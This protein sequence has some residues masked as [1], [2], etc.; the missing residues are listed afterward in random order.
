MA[1]KIV[2]FILLLG[3]LYWAYQTG[4]LDSLSSGNLP[5]IGKE[6]KLRSARKGAGIPIA[7]DKQ[8]IA[9][10]ID[11]HLGSES[12]KLVGG[13]QLAGLY[14]NGELVKLP[15]DTKARVAERSTVKVQSML[16]QI[17][18]VRILSGNNKGAVGW[19]ERENV[20]DTPLHEL[21]QSV[22]SG[23]GS[24]RRRHNVGGALVPMST[25]D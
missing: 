18:K 12:D 16:F 21:Y 15:D 10:A 5:K 14:Q 23:S 8:T 24:D 1:F 9:R 6:V 7:G 19:V 13:V 17:V 2:F 11:S 25:E 3:G 20:I 4:I 22:A